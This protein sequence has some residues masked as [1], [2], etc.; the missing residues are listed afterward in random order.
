MSIKRIECFCGQPIEIDAP[1]GTKFKCPSCGE[2]WSVPGPMRV[3]IPSVQTPT[4]TVPPVSTSGGNN[5]VK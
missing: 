1:A 5:I 2:P 4:Y 3:E